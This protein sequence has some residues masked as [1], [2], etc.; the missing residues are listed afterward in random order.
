MYDTGEDW[1]ALLDDLAAMGIEEADDDNDDEEAVRSGPPRNGAGYRASSRYRSGSASRGSANRGGSSAG[2]GRPVSHAAPQQGYASGVQGTSQATMDTPR[3]P[4]RLKMPQGLVTVPELQE[5]VDAIQDDV[6]ANAAGIRELA[7]RHRRDTACLAALIR[8]T[9][10][11][12][13]RG[14]K[15]SE[16]ASILAASAP[17][18]VKLIQRQLTPA[19]APPPDQGGEPAN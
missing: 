7:A 4:A 12:L 13:T 1:D 15:H 8:K 3:G 18:I 2:G 6:K 10:K 11:K 9:D 16:L 14:L 19:P 17:L 5:T